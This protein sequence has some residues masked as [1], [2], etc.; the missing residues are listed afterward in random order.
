MR[1]LLYV[2][3]GS[4]TSL[5]PPSSSTGHQTSVVLIQDAVGLPSVPADHVYAL[6]DDITSGGGS[7]SF[8]S[9][10]YRDFLRL[11]FE[12]DGVVAL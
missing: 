8:P 1:H 6:A 3:S 4:D 7:T 11:I 12:A 10:S 9:V 2:L 5:L